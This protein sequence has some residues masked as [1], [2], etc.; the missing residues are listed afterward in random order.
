MTDQL[1]SMAAHAPSDDVIA[2]AHVDAAKYDSMAA[3]GLNAARHRTAKKA[4]ADGG[5]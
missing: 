4:T 1:T 3:A 5:C 2:K